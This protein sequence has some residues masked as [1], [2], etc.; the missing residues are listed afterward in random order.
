MHNPTARQYCL[1]TILAAFAAFIPVAV[2]QS[3]L[4]NYSPVSLADLQD[5]PE[6]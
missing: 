4:D 6:K 3:L 5:P 1:A 2:A